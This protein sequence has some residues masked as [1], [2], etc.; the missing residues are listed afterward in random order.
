MK[1]TETRWVAK[2]I[3]KRDS[4]KWKR[5]NDFHVISVACV[6]IFS[7]YTSVVFRWN[8]AQYAS[9]F[10]GEKSKT[11]FHKK[12]KDAIFYKT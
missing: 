10:K 5:Y 6:L 7:Q 3:I 12:K 1:Q 11:I 9:N 4:C 2:Q 8:P